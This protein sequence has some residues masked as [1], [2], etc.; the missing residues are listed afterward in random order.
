MRPKRNK[1]RIHTKR[2]IGVKIKI[3]CIIKL[4]FNFLIIHDILFLIIIHG[5][6]IYSLFVLFRKHSIIIIS[7]FIAPHFYN[8]SSLVWRLVVL[9]GF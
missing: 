6:I 8:I 1:F 7:V 5:D 9:T 2:I 4:Y 3:F